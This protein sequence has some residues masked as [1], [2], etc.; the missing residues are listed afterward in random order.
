MGMYEITFS[1]LN[2][3]LKKNCGAKPGPL[4]LEEATV[5]NFTLASIFFPQFRPLILDPAVTTT[6]T[7][8]TII[9]IIIIVVVNTH[10]GHVESERRACQVSWAV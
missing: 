7:T 10:T 5:Y 6:T 1:H 8:T 4:R 9:V 2:I 3:Q